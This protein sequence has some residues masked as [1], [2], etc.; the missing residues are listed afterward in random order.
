MFDNVLITYFSYENNERFNKN[1]AEGVKI[2]DY[3]K[4]KD[5]KI[6]VVENKNLSHDSTLDT[7]INKQHYTVNFEHLYNIFSNNGGVWHIENQE[8]SANY[9]WHV[10]NDLNRVDY[11]VIR[12]D[13]Q[14]NLDETNLEEIKLDGVFTYRVLKN[15]KPTELKLSVLTLEDETISIDFSQGGNSSSFIL[16][17]FHGQEENGNWTSEEAVLV[18]ESEILSDFEIKVNGSK[19]IEENEIGF[20]FDGNIVAGEDIERTDLGYSLYIDEEYFNGDKIIHSLKM[21]DYKAVS[22]AMLSDEYSDTRILSFLLMKL[23]YRMLSENYFGSWRI[24][25]C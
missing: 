22:P 3:F 9:P 19:F 18:F 4:D 20:E 2:N 25:P 17:G 12:N 24:E 8:I 5:G 13:F 10:Y 7:Y 6:L 11:L 1:V 14:M 16:S 15:N 23:L 21:T